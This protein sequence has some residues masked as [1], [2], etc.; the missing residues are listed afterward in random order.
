MSIESIHKAQL[1]ALDSLIKAFEVRRDSAVRQI[2]SKFV[3]KQPL[4]QAHRIMVNNEW[5][6]FIE[7]I[8][9]DNARIDASIAFLESLKP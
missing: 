6:E 5:L 8:S 1:D 2:Q 3:L 7:S 4:E 9:A